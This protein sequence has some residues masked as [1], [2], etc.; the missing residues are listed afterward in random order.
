M[1]WYRLLT[2]FYFRVQKEFLA[3]SPLLPKDISELCIRGVNYLGC[4]M[5]W[6]LR[7]DDVCVILREQ[8]SGAGD[9][10]S[11]GL[12]VVLKASGMKI[13][14]TPGNT[15]GLQSIFFFNVRRIIYTINMKLCMLV[16]KNACHSS[17]YIITLCEI[18]LGAQN[19]S[20]KMR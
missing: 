19:L 5:D 9:A 8:A 10:K 3:F 12:Q 18:I 17:K 11:Y 13:P 6:L 7:K 14:L 2:R 16:E 15:Q 4:Q 20:D 1:Q